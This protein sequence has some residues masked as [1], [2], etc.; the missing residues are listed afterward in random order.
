MHATDDLNTE[1]AYIVTGT[2]RGIGRALAKVIMDQGYRLYSLNRQPDSKGGLQHNFYCDLSD[3][4]Q[5][6]KTMIRLLRSIDPAGCSELVLINNA[7]VLGPILPLELLNDDH[8]QVNL[9]TNLV[10]PI[11]LI[12]QFIRSAPAAVRARRIINITSG[13]AHHAYA[14]WSMYCVA[15]AALNMITTCV[16]LEQAQRNPQ[17]AICAVAPGV[18]DTDMQQEIRQTSPEN[19]PMKERFLAFQRDGKLRNPENVAEL[20]LA[21]DRSGQFV[22]GGLYDLRSVRWEDGRPTIKPWNGET[23]EGVHR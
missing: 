17:V 2:T 11:Q 21:L 1:T 19:F 3:S 23:S 6:R 4:H 20:I 16:A 15:K 9:H 7:G 5:V 8:L 22:S 10:A 18:V 12:S 14:G 13:A